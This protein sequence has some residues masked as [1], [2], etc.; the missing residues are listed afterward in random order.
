MIENTDNWGTLWN[1][2]VENEYPFKCEECSSNDVRT[3]FD[4]LYEESHNYDWLGSNQFKTYFVDSD[5]APNTI[6]I[7]DMFEGYIFTEHIKN[8]ERYLFSLFEQK[9]SMGL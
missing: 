3:V 9:S 8:I 7:F 5:F 1:E 4:V 2:I 6:Y